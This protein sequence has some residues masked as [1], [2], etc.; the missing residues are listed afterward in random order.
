MAKQ[1][2]KLFFELSDGADVN[3]IVMTLSGCMEWIKV[4]TDGLGETALNEYTI[5]P[6]FMTER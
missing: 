3:C 6:V 2:K 1:E 5:K 4:D